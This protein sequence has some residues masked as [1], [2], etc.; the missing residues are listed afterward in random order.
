MNKNQIV[1]IEWVDSFGCSPNWEEIKEEYNPEPLVCKSVGWLLYDGVDCKIIVPHIT[2]E[3]HD[4]AIQQGCGDMTIPASA[5]L[6]IVQFA[7]VPT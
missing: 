2:T 3:K 6:K 4:H 7:N 5:I 1:Y